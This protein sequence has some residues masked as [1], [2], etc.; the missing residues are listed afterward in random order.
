ML[1]HTC[2]NI[3]P[4]SSFST[5]HPHHLPRFMKQYIIIHSLS[6]QSKKW[7]SLTLII[8]ALTIHTQCLTCQFVDHQEF[9]IFCSH[10][11]QHMQ[12]KIIRMQW[13]AY[14]LQKIYQGDEPS[15]LIL[16]VGVRW[17]SK[18]N[19]S[20]NNSNTPKLFP[21]YIASRQG[22]KLIFSLWELS[23]SWDSDSSAF[24][25]ENNWKRSKSCHPIEKYSLYP[26]ARF[27][28]HT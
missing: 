7:E 1:I 2:S 27:C 20:P 19:S 8:K 15:T 18:S 26:I 25:Y 13:N 28:A 10:V 5:S 11:S 24:L 3:H 21:H 9:P 22:K 23:L 4:V 6:M 16:F 14:S 12:R 17:K